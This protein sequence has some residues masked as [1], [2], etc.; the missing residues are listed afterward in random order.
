VSC[1]RDWTIC[2]WD[3]SADGDPLVVLKGHVGVY[4]VTTYVAANGD[5]RVVSCGHDKIQIWDPGDDGDALVVV[6]HPYVD[7]HKPRWFLGVT[8]FV[9]SDDKVRIVSCGAEELRVW[10]SRGDALLLLE[11]HAFSNTSGTFDAYERIPLSDLGEILYVEDVTTYVASNGEMRVVSC[12]NDGTLLVWDPIAGGDAL[13]V[14]WGHAGRDE[15]T[16]PYSSIL[17]DASISSVTTYVTST[18]ETR[19]VSCADDKTVRIWDAVEGQERFSNHHLLCIPLEVEC[20][21]LCV[22]DTND[23]RILVFGHA[24]GSVTYWDIL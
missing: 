7:A 2:T 19:V 3:P 12:A 10:N 22:V 15:E 9:T 17:Y 14:L 6:N 4:R 21:A 1:A 5:V 20:K 16:G 8:T 11:G 18:G 23:S 13:C 24:D